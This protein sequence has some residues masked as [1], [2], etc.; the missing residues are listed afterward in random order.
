MK[1][2]IVKPNHVILVLIIILFNIKL[3]A[4]TLTSICNITPSAPSFNVLSNPVCAPTSTTYI[5]KYRI[6]QTYSPNNNSALIVCNITLH[7]F[8][9]SDG[10]ADPGL[11]EQSPSATGNPT[12]LN[13]YLSWMTNGNQERF[14]TLRNANYAPSFMTS[15]FLDSKIQYSVTNIYYYPNTSLYTNPSIPIHFAYIDS[16]YPGRLEEGLPILIANTG[17]KQLSGWNNKPAVASSVGYYD[18]D[19]FLNHYKHE[20]GHCFGLGH[21]YEDSPWC[22]NYGSDITAFGSPCGSVNYLSDVFVPGQPFCYF[23]QNGACPLIYISAN[24][25]NACGSCHEVP[26]TGL[27][28]ES[29]NFMGASTLFG[30]RWISPI[31]MGRR[32]R[33]MRLNPMR[34]FA[35]DLPSDHIN[36]WN[37]TNSETWDFDIQMY[38]DIVV[39]TGNTLKVTC[40]INMAR[41]G[42]IIV[43]KG[44]KLIIDGGEITTWSKTGRWDG[45]YLEGTSNMPQYLPEQSQLEIKN[46]ALIQNAN[47][48]VNTFVLDAS[49]NINWNSTGGIIFAENSTFLNN[50]KDVQFMYYH[51]PNGM[52]NVCKF[53]NVTFKIDDNYRYGST[54]DARV[55]LYEVSGVQFLGCSLINLQA[56]VDGNNNY[57]FRS[58]DAQY[59]IDKLGTTNSFIHRFTYGVYADNSNPLRLVSVKNT[60]IDQSYQDGAYFNNIQSPVFE[61]NTVVTPNFNWNFVPIYSG[62]LYLNNCKGYNI[63]NNDFSQLVNPYGKKDVGIYVNNSKTGTHQIYRNNFQNF[64]IGID[65]MNDNSGITNYSDGLKMNCNNFDFPNKN[66]Y[67]ITLIADNPSTPP[68][69][70]YWQGSSNLANVSQYVRNRYGALAGTSGTDENQWYI[71]NTSL[72]YIWHPSYSNINTRPIPQP[73]LSDVS[74]DVQLNSALFD[75]NYCPANTF[76]PPSGGCPCPSCCKLVQINSGIVLANTEVANATNAYNMALDGGNTATL[77]AAVNGN[78]SNGNLKNLL[79]SKSPYLSD[80]VLNA[81]F[82][83]SATPPGHI[84]DIHALNAPVSAVVWQT[85]QNINLPNG[86]RNQIIAK[87]NEKKFSSRDLLSGGITNAKYNLQALTT[88]KLNYFVLDTL[89]QSKDSVIKVLQ[90]N[91]TILPNALTNLFFAYINKG[92]ID[93]ALNVRTQIAATD[94]K[95]AEYLNALIQL[96]YAPNKA[97]KLQTD[98]SLNQF[99][100]NYA[101]NSNETNYFGAQAALKFVLN[102]NYQVPRLFP[103]NSFTARIG[104][105]IIE[106]STET[107]DNNFSLYPNPT[108]GMLY[109]NY[110]KEKTIN[111]V[112]ICDVLGKIVYKTEKLESNTLQI[113]LNGLS[114]GV[115]FFNAYTN[116]ELVYRSK[117]VK[118]N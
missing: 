38:E 78:M 101:F 33:A 26:Q 49:N 110:D 17:W 80:A 3:T 10:T 55:S 30:Y 96:Q 11:W 117:F 99:M 114:S 34:S 85:I 77:V 27:G 90:Q 107:F 94:S 64:N 39:K 41:E 36:T 70:M 4:Q 54:P 84:K 67:D 81:Y 25:S 12:L 19:F 95:Y 71:Q 66:K 57:A 60:F 40:K 35:A 14:S 46:N 53:K 100:Q 47:I 65:A 74:V 112:I 43:E 48:A 111:K 58:Y 24:P 15:Q 92:S 22:G 5:N 91:Q 97:F 116:T 98:E 104:S 72:K 20:L 23:K 93:E 113:N 9:N 21:T 109:F 8:T 76:T 42:R 45:I 13:N 32:I 31:Q 108:N 1:K 50:I 29:N 51:S 89:P 69:V 16:L 61:D 44:A 37:I 118:A 59:F 106:E 82:T 103:E 2:N 102:T 56:T 62:G 7:I 79:E 68:N 18:L 73:N 6:P 28:F 105:S 52:P 88:E 83:R 75:P 115:Y 86:I 87:Q 63:K